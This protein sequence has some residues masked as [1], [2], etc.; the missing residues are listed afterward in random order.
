[1]MIG[2]LKS[3]TVVANT[4]SSLA[5]RHG[6]I[7]V[8]TA[9]LI[10]GTTAVPARRLPTGEELSRPLATGKP[11]VAHHM[12]KKI[13]GMGLHGQHR[14]GYRP[15]GNYP[16]I[17]GFYHV[18]PLLGER[19]YASTRRARAFE[20]RCAVEMGVDAFSL[21]YP[22]TPNERDAARYN[23]ATTQFAHAISDAAPDRFKLALFIADARLEGTID[24]RLQIA[25]ERIRDV[26]RT[27]EGTDPW[28]RTPDG[29]MVV[30]LYSPGKMLKGTR[31][32]PMGAGKASI[33]AHLAAQAD[34]WYRLADRVDERVAFVYF[35]GTYQ[36]YKQRW[37]L[38]EPEFRSRYLYLVNRVYDY[39]PAVTHFAWVPT[40][41]S[42]SLH[43]AMV[44]L[45]RRR[46]RAFVQN[47]M[48]DYYMSKLKVKVP[49]K[50][51]RSVNAGDA[52][53]FRKVDNG[54][55]YRYYIPTRGSWM[56]RDHLAKAVRNDSQMVSL[57][58]W[59]DYTEG[60]HLAPGINHNFA[61]SLVLR[62]YLALWRGKTSPFTDEIAVFYKKYPPGVKP[63][64]FNIDYH[65]PTWLISEK[66]FHQY[67]GDENDIDVV[68]IAGEPA[69]L[70]VNGENHGPV[71]AGIHATRVP[72]KI[73]RVT[74]RL[75]RGGETVATLTSP[76]W[77]TDAP[78]RSDRMTFAYS[79]ICEA[80]YRRLFGKRMPVSQE[81][82]E[83]NGVP[84][85]KRNYDLPPA[86]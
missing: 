46:K 74:A 71:P 60:H 31:A 80:M 38:S 27:T 11:V 78:Y 85:W 29:R 13:P 53:L 23:R 76:E 19:K 4:F 1:M 28:L 22:L 83:E 42:R 18:L 36:M 40:P 2:F 32:P 72:L 77:I 5:G 26:F 14:S 52:E 17:G 58:T 56:F 41:E 79:T 57:V 16:S 82:A 12:T 30:F 68:T 44:A 55:M 39:F 9:A 47:A 67:R 25:A 51:W 3:S 33:D 43:R 66:A 62:H 73:G 59:N 64:H 86:D 45:A 37:G 35:V 20:I 70:F 54:D 63:S 10:A 34:L 69:T 48:L 50:G 24:E 49:G 84:G 8:T 81:Y 15:D 7:A 65:R 21:Y 6:R 75:V 61:Y